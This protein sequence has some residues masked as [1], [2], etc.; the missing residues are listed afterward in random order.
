MFTSSTPGIELAHAYF[1]GFVAPLLARQVPGVRYAA[2][3]V[4][5]GSEGLGLDDAMSRDHDWGLRLQL[6]VA[7]AEQTPVIAALD[8]HLPDTFRGHPVRFG[9]S[10]D[11]EQRTRI[12]VTSVA[13]FADDRLGFD[14]R[15]APS[16]P[17]TG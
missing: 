11:P 2:A 4:G 13:A 9:F 5:T 8:A 17:P 7:E 14:P 12:D 6:F 10:A 16:P 3:R 15:D 1:E